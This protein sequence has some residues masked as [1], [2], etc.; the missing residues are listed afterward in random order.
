MLLYLFDEIAD[1]AVVGGADRYDFRKAKDGKLSVRHLLLWMID[2]VDGDNDRFPSG[3]KLF[4]QKAIDRGDAIFGVADKNDDIG[5]LH[6]QIGFRSYLLLV[7]V[8]DVSFDAPGI[9]YCK[10][11]R[12]KK[13]FRDQPVAGDAGLIMDDGNTLLGQAVENRGFANV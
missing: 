5:H 11:T 7:I 9:N 6:G 8:V 12:A 3:T 13:A 1:T 10:W 4:G 2:F